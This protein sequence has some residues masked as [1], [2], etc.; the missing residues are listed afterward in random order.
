MPHVATQDEVIALINLKQTWHATCIVSGMSVTT[1]IANALKPQQVV[2]AIQQ[3]SAKTGVDFSYLMNKAQLESGL[4]CDAKAKT[5]SACGL[6]QFTNSTWLQTMR[7][8]GADYGLAKYADA[9][10]DNGKVASSDM[11]QKILDLRKDPE[12]SALMAAEYAKDNKD[13][14]SSKVSGP[15]GQTELYL[16]H[17]MGAGGAAKFLHAK[18]SKPDAKAANIFGDEA[19]A[20]HNI[21]YDKAGNARTVKQVYQ[22]FE[23]KLSKAELQT[24]SM[25]GDTNLPVGTPVAANIK[26]TTASNFATQNV[27]SA[28]R[29]SLPSAMDFADTDSKQNFSSNNSTNLLAQAALNSAN[30]IQRESYFHTLVQ[31]QLLSTALWHNQ[32]SHGVSAGF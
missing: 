26:S 4:D 30:D 7:D 13:Y 24:A 29:T 14:L 19:A 31:T 1:A 6:Y 3:A 32:D 21:F 5:S 16:A 17:F 11:R 15:I 22:L 28:M 23:Q 8:H 18:E 20:N 27:I 12:T 2:A 9:I 10:D 25:S